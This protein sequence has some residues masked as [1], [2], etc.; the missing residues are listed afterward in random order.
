VQICRRLDGIPLAL[1][2]AAARVEALTAEQVALRLDQRFRLLTVGSRAALPR[3]QTL[4][5]TPDWSYDLLRQP[6]RLWFERLAVC[7]G[8]WTLEAA[9]AVCAGDGLDDEDVLDVLAN[10]TRKSLVV[11][12]EAIDGA[13]RYSLLE[14]VRDYARTKLASRGAAEIT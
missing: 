13:E 7:S 5:A 12:E 2:L 3:Q 11:A 1:E 4:A 8:G 9:E 6:A 14:T 10:L